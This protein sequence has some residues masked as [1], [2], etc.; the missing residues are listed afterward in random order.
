MHETLI[1]CG[2]NEFVHEYSFQREKF[3]PLIDLANVPPR[4]GRM[5]QCCACWRM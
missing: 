3:C 1:N 2:L 5:D 4:T